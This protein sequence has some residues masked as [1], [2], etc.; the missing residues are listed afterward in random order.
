MGGKVPEEYA[1]YKRVFRPIHPVRLTN[2]FYIAETET[3]NQQFR[4]HYA[5]HDSGNNSDSLTLNE[6]KQP[7]VRI[8]WTDASAF[9]EDYGYRLPTEAEWE[10]ACRAGTDTNYYWGDSDYDGREY[11][12]MKDRSEVVASNALRHKLTEDSTN[13]ERLYAELD[14]VTTLTPY[15][16]W[17]DGYPATAPVGKFKPNGFGL[18]D[19]SGNVYEWCSDCYDPDE[20]E[21]HREGAVDPQG[22]LVGSSRVR[23][24]G[25]WLMVPGCCSSFDRS[26][27]SRVRRSQD[28]GFRSVMETN[29][30]VFEKAAE[31]S[32]DR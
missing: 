17:N 28:L 2:A 4:K 7:V 30:V 23:R 12:N 16:P 11:A 10:Y 21:R 25:S 15:Y 3:T 5:S 1:E 27:R 22:P 31:E 13:L 19:M 14:L 8:T 24:G 26:A 20:Y 6:P 32:R 29:R 18:Y 9:C